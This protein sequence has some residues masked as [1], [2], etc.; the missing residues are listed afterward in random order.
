MKK[1]IGYLFAGLGLLGL[2]LNSTVGKKLVPALESV[3]KL[4]VIVPSFILL[5][6]GVVV[7]ILMGKSGGDGLIKQVENEVPIYRGEGKKRKIVGY[8]A[9]D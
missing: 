2:A 6:L 8:K 3:P 7:L 9:E 4:Y 5:V 1:Y